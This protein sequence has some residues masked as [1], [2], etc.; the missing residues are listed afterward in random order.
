VDR[1]EARRAPDDSDVVAHGRERHVGA[2][3]CQQVARPVAGGDDDRA[4][5]DRLARHRLDRLHAAARHTD[6][7]DGDA[8]ADVGAVPARSGRVA[9]RRAV[10]IGVARVRLPRGGADS[11]HRHA[12]LEGTQ[13]VWQQHAGVDAHRARHGDVR[14]HGAGVGGTE[15]RQE[16]RPV[17]TSVAAD[18]LAEALEDPTPGERHPDQRLVRVVRSHDRARAACG[19]GREVV[20]LQQHD[21]PGAE[22]REVP[23]RAG[24]FASAAADHNVGRSGVA[25]H[26]AW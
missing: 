8:D 19:A 5:R 3:R 16:A 15:E 23:R 26:R 17:E 1:A 21:A 24:A 10:R 2:E 13:L 7:G 14:A 25:H 22:A 12:R 4:G 6:R 11:V 18:D 20:A 9:H